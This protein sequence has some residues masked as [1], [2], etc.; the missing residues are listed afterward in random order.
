MATEDDSGRRRWPWIVAGVGI[1][2]LV[3]AYVIFTSGGFLEPR[4]ERILTD[5]LDAETRIQGMD[6]GL[7]AG[8]SIDHI[9]LSVPPRGEKGK[10]SRLVF[11]D[12]L[13]E[14]DLS[15]LLTGSYVMDRVRVS[16]MDADVRP[17]FREWIERLQDKPRDGEGGAV[18]DVEIRQGGVRFTDPSLPRPVR[19]DNLSL[20][21]G[22]TRPARLSGVVSFRLGGNRIRLNITAAPSQ[23]YGDVNVTM[24]G[25]DLQAIPQVPRG[26]DLFDPSK[27]FMDGA[28]TGELSVPLGTDSVPPFSGHFSLADS[29]VAYSG[30]PLE[31]TNLSAQIRLTQNGISLSDIKTNLGRGRVTITTARARLDGGELESVSLRGTARDLNLENL[32]HGS[33][34]WSTFARG[35]WGRMYSGSADA[36]FNLQWAPDSKLSYEAR[37]RLRDGSLRVERLDRRLDDV[38][39]EATVDSSG[40]VSIDS[41]RVPVAGGEVEASGSL[42]LLNGEVRDPRL[43]LRL[44][45]VVPTPEV[46][47]SFEP[48]MSEILQRVKLTHPR[49]SGDVTVSP[50]D[51]SCDLDIS[52]R[53]VKPEDVPYRL[54]DFSTDMRW[55]SSGSVI[56]FRN[57]SA[58]RNGGQ[59]EGDVSANLSGRPTLEATLF[60]RAVPIDDQLLGLFPGAVRDRMR[61]W[62]PAG[63]FDF[64]VRCQNW[65]APESFSTEA[66]REVGVNVYLRDIS[67]S[68]PGSPSLVHDLYGHISLRDGIVNLTD[69]NGQMLGASARLNGSVPLPGVEGSSNLRMETETVNVDPD[70]LKT[71][72]GR[73]GQSMADMNAQGQLAVRADVSQL[74]TG[75]QPLKATGSA[76]I[77]SFE[78]SPKNMRLRIGGTSRVE[79]KWQPGESP[80]LSGTVRLREAETA[81]ISANRVS[82]RFEYREQTL[83]IPAFETDA[84]G[85]KITAKETRFNTVTGMWE[86]RV[87]YAHMD[88][89][90]LMGAFDIRG[91]EAP[92][93]VLRGRL[94]VSGTRMN[95]E[96]FN[97]AGQVRIDRGRL[98]S[99]PVLLSVFSVLDLGLPSQSPVSDALGNYKVDDGVLT[100]QDLVFSG[101][102]AMPVHVTGTVSLEEG[103]K[104]K[105]R[106]INMLV[107]VTKRR[108]VLDAIPIIGFIKHY[109]IDLLRR[110]IMQARVRGTFADYEVSTI[111]D[112][113]T[114][115]I[116]AIWSLVP[117]LN[118][119]SS[120]KQ[121]VPPVPPALEE[122]VER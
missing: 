1:A 13:V 59:V 58:R 80:E 101:G 48:S 40:L 23:G 26:T 103:E 49:V 4:I 74:P 11:E 114:R 117:R 91:E 94:E 32:T 92:G 25:F 95:P 22:S 118:P 9:S 46:M 108:G 14:H 39:V 66:L 35:D 37:V 82:A 51:V 88:L 105:N 24:H 110:F 44:S 111:A 102:G 54:T 81:R 57:I 65:Q 79:A 5:R 106:K 10:S 89:E 75:E 76:V 3:I 83:T 34:P 29:S 16:R 15:A 28:L 2:A 119:V 62:Q 98:Y 60:G 27:L 42:R 100:I 99:F 41:A 36:D 52:A 61:R 73:M 31:L 112:P 87:E 50:N 86:T 121:E 84:Y 113:V 96:T 56:R 85:G 30:W 38:N 67:L 7:F 21:L 120:A 20:L 115:P 53:A 63:K 45:E 122:D 69:V 12:C 47:G 17:G 6:F 107:T 64:E 70:W 8:T 116:Q 68:H 77:H 43:S 71:L 104:F 109:T 33:L 55:S 19:V 93:G 18:P 78:I 72:P 90:S 97:G